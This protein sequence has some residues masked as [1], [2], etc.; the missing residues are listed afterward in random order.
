MTRIDKELA[1]LYSEY[2]LLE[3]PVSAAE[4]LIINGIL[5]IVDRNNTCWDKF[6]VRLVIQNDYPMS[7]PTI[8]ET[9]RRIPRDGKWHINGDD[10]CCV[11]TPA[12]QFSKLH[13]R[14]TILNWF[15]Q[16]AIP[17]FANFIFKKDKG[18]YYNGEW[19]HGPKG[20]FEHYSMLFETD[21]LKFL[22]E[23]LRCC[24]GRDKKSLNVPCFCGSGK[25]YKRCYVLQPDRHRYNIPLHVMLKDI[26]Q[27][28]AFERNF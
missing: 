12:E 15:R 28:E 5:P 17:F 19:S 27:L 13:G 1:E 21:D 22:L 18:D 9:G 20:I 10:T 14:L 16:F 11:G 8:T 26:E 25:K 7:L 4:R 23:R 24:I 3:A 6:S 2:P